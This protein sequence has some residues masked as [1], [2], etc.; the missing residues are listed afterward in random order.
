MYKQKGEMEADERTSRQKSSIHSWRK[1]YERGHWEEGVARGGEGCAEAKWEGLE[2]CPPYLENEC[3]ESLFKNVSIAMVGM[4]ARPTE[5]KTP[6]LPV[7][8]LQV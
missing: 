1:K 5:E 3:C 8:S 7:S 6:R 2:K 4:A